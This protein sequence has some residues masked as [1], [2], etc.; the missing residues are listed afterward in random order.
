MTSPF[1]CFVNLTVTCWNQTPLLEYT[2]VFCLRIS[3]Q[4]CR[5]VRQILYGLKWSTKSEGMVRCHLQGMLQ[6]LNSSHITSNRIS[7]RK[8]SGLGASH[9]PLLSCLLNPAGSTGSSTDHK[10]RKKGE[11]GREIFRTCSDKT[12]DL[13][14]RSN[15]NEIALEYM[16]HIAMYVSE[17]HFVIFLSRN[18]G[19]RAR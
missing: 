3:V 6:Y 11:G 12:L 8:G 7:T 15:Y 2:G 9:I 5:E 17:G 13:L 14:V 16:D 18:K 4:C 10:S 1:Y 19:Y